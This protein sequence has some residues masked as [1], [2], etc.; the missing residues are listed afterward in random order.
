M[1]ENFTILDGIVTSAFSMLVVLI[2]LILLTYILKLFSKI[3]STEKKE[4]T[5]NKDHLLVVQI[6]AGILLQEENPGNVQIR[7]I[8]KVK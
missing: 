7:S 5:I 8:K 6:L 4:E 2:T 1:L 3:L